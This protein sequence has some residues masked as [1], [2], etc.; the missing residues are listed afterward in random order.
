MKR[1]P[2]NRSWWQRLRQRLPGRSADVI[3]A[4]IGAGARDVVV[5]KNILRIGALV[6]PALPV[7]I[8][9]VAALL[10]TTLGL[11]LYLVPAAM[12]PGYVNIAI[13]RFGRVDADG[14][15]HTSADT[16]LIGRT[17]FATV[18]DE[19]RRLAPDYY[20]QVWHDGMGLLKARD[21][22]HGGGRH[23]ARSLAGRLRAR[24]CGG[25][26]NSCVYGE[27]DARQPRRCCGSACA[28]TTRTASAIWATSLSYSASTGW[29]ARCRWCC[30]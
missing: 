3:V 25:C 4:T 20:G 11:W 9:L 27:L 14:R 7:V 17:L 19:V 16:D 8:A 13:A 10:S 22:R 24:D 23:C 18:R 21:N 2:P 5:G 12:P 1:P 15:I 29:A 6:V 28:S 30:R 26:A